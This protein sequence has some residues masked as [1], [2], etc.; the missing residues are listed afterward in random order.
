MIEAE[1]AAL[2]HEVERIWIDRLLDEVARVAE[3]FVHE[4]REIGERSAAALGPS[5]AS[6][7]HPAHVALVMAFAKVFRHAQDR[8]NEVPQRIVR[9]YQEEVLR[10]APRGAAPDSVFLTIA[11]RPGA[12]PRIEEGTLFP[13]GKDASGAAV[14][15]AAD[16]ALD[17][18]GARLA[19]VRLWSPAR[20]G[21]DGIAWVDAAVFAVGPDGT[22]GEDGRGIAGPGTRVAVAPAA[23][24]AAPAL[25]LAGGTRRLTLTLACGRL[26][27]AIIPAMLGASLNVAVSTGKG[28]LDL[29]GAGVAVHWKR[30]ADAITFCAVLPPNLPPIAPCPDGTPDAPGEA[31][32]RLT[33]R[34]EVA[35]TLAPWALFSG[36]TLASATL[37]VAVKDAGDLV[38]ST[39][40][41]L[42]SAVGAAPF[43]TPP[44]PGGWLRIDHPVLA[45]RPLDRLLL[46]LDWAGLPAGRTGFTG[47]YREYVVDQDRRLRDFPLFT[48]LSFAVTMAAPVPGWDVARRLPLFAAADPAATPPAAAPPPDIFDPG[49][50]FGAA[51]A[52]PAPD[53]RLAPASWFAAAASAAPAGPIPD[54]LLV[55]LAAPQEGFGDAAYPANV[56]YATA[57]LAWGEAPGRRRGLLG[58]IWDWVVALPEDH[59]GACEEGRREASRDPQGAGR[60]AAS[61]AG[62]GHRRLYRCPAR[63]AGSGG[64]GGGA[65]SGSG[66]LRGAAQSAVSYFAR[67]YVR[68]DY[69]CRVADGDDADSLQL[70]HGAPLE[71]LRRRAAI[72]D[73]VL[74]AAPRSAGDR[75]RA[76]A[77]ARPGDPQALLVRLGPRR[78]VG[79]EA[80][81]APACF[82]HAAAGWRPLPRRA[83][84]SDRTFGFNVA[85]IV[86]IALPGT[87][88]RSRVQR[89]CGFGS[90]R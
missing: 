88:P 65:G 6:G 47:Y 80:S 13:A 35:G 74:R 48:N 68:L 58:W 52:A 82:Y 86:A 16:V 49:E 37:D 32:M 20:G 75:H 62:R 36:I 19:E 2:R 24:I 66:S 9:F 50:G 28:W 11:P 1:V 38:V 63:R 41:G 51:M 15:F 21:D 42:A 56:A 85:G 73:A 18:T 60:A 12:R 30:M 25:R 71:G 14:A 23:V 81:P 87:R 7:R 70:W 31:A 33:L 3:A 17:V 57:L 44:Y 40:S 8:L 29:G 79:G 83:S 90:C 10:D 54:H 64:G 46:H 39:P 78:G 53:S 59:P 61:Q 69:A 77:D 4:M 26:P 84:L 72:A 22:I 67:A 27:A 76:F 55:T 34:H 89:G 45:A 43:G 5:L